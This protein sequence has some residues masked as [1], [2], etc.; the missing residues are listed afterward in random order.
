[1]FTVYCRLC[2]NP[3]PL[4]EIVSL[5]DTYKG[6]TIRDALL[7]LFQ[8]EILPTEMLSTICKK[9][10]AKVCTVRDIREEFI[11]QDL[12][13]QQMISSS[14]KEESL[15]VQQQTISKPS[16]TTA[17]PSP[18][19]ESTTEEQQSKQEEANGSVECLELSEEKEKVTSDNGD[20][21]SIVY[22]V[23]QSND[24]DGQDTPQS[25][26]EVTLVPGSSGKSPVRFK[27]ANCLARDG[28][29]SEEVDVLEAKNDEDNASVQAYCT[30]SKDIADPSE[31]Q[32]G[33]KETVDCTNLYICEWCDTYFDTHEAYMAHVCTERVEATET[34]E[35]Q[36]KKRPLVGR[37]NKRALPK[38]TVCPHCSE[39]FNMDKH[40]VQHM[41]LTHPDQV[42]IINCTECTEQF[43]TSDALYEHERLRHRTGHQ[44]KFC[45][46]ELPNAFALQSHEN[47]HTKRQTFSC[48]VCNK[49]F[50]QYSSMWRHRLIHDDI[51]AYE[52]DVCQRRFRQRTVMLAHRLVHTGEKPYTCGICD[53]SFRDRSTLA[54][55]GQV[56]TRLRVLRKKENMAS[57]E[58]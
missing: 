48:P 42:E 45:G 49:R 17:E 15:S 35:S 50:S 47:V 38:T 14:S 8:I 57:T 13:Y 37:A 26:F 24:A 1:M 40:L 9:C 29:D 10:V 22:Y 11:T 51:K 20:S 18:E 25:E 3:S 19:A 7:E 32:P 16:Q 28:Y 27:I 55:H 54:R 36:S 31:A 46:K 2:L 12:K 39:V 53:K 56:H 43:A 33:G 6:F 41:K 30:Y 21:N 4:N 5:F 44:C 52:C 58:V 34:H 23:E